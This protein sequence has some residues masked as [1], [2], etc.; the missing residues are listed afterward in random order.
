LIEV[1]K[2]VAGYSRLQVLRDVTLTVAAGELVTVVGANGAGKSTLLRC[3]QGVLP[4]VSGRVVFAGQDITSLSIERI[5]RMGLTLVPETRDLFPELSVIDNV[6]LGA[7]VHRHEKDAEARRR[8][9]LE[10]VFDLF[11]AIQERK[12]E[13]AAALSGGQQQMLAIGRA[14]MTRPRALMLDEPSL[15]LAPLV[16]KQIFGAIDRLR[17]SGLAILLVEQNVR[18]ALRLAERAYVLDTGRIVA[19]GPAAAIMRDEAVTSVYLGKR[20]EAAAN[21]TVGSS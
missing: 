9:G 4:A 17:K 11:P 12:A 5:V 1:E 16:I 15:G 3:I 6:L 19:H 10:M 8:D 13:R 21:R 18:A 20:T 2:L 14:L 7:F